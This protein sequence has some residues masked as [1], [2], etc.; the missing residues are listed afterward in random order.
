MSDGLQKLRWVG[1]GVSGFLILCFLSPVFA[2]DG[3]NPLVNRCKNAFQKVDLP[4]FSLLGSWKLKRLCSQV[5]SEESVRAIELIVAVGGILY[6]E[7]LSAVLKINS[8]HALG[9]VEA[10]ASQGY[11][12]VDNS[13]GRILALCGEVNSDGIV[14]G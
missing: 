4:P 7:K 12:L 13:S 11:K 1:I 6:P 5:H 10:F 2:S 14:Q 8:P 9:C 3:E